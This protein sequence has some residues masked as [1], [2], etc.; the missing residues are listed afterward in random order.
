MSETAATY[1]GLCL[2]AV[3]A[4]AVNALAGGG[5]L[6]TFPALLAVLGN[7]PANVTSTVALVPGSVGGAWG[8]RRELRP[9]RGWVLLLAGPSFAGGLLGALLLILLDDRYF[10][11]LIPWL[12]LTATLLLVLRPLLSPHVSAGAA[13]P[14]PSPRVVAAVVAGQFLIAVYGGYFGAGIG[15]LML[16]TLG[17]MGLHDIHQMNAVKNLLAVLI[18][19]VSVVVFAASGQVAWHFALPM[20]GCAVLGGYL[21]ASAARRVNPVAVRGAVIAIGLGLSAYF[22]WREFTGE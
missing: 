18:N 2:S 5:T 7:V 15:I 21:G 8:Y 9:V 20:A 14:A 13:P 11:A 19:G 17:L 4:G 16:G 12:I 6:L 1:A 22:F 10:E 3:A